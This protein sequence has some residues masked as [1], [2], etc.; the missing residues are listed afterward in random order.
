MAN[1]FNKF[2]GSI[3]LGNGISEINKGAIGEGIKSLERASRS[4]N[5]SEVIETEL[6]KISYKIYQVENKKNS[7]DAFALL[8]VMYERL[9]SFEER[10]PYSFNTQLFLTTITWEMSKRNPELFRDE[11][12]G[13]YI[14]LR[15]LM[16]Q[17][18]GPQEILSNVLVAV[19]EI[20]LGKNE[21]EIGIKMS[22]LAGITSAQSWWVKGEAERFQGNTESAIDSF[23]NSIDEASISTNLDYDDAEHRDFAFL[24]LSYQS[25]ALMYEN[26]DANMA[27]KYIQEAIKIAYNTG[28]A[29]LLNPRF[30]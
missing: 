7:A 8:P 10:S 15:N 29:L 26:I 30:R 22:D 3:N 19:G 27:T 11:A 28:N 6:F 24:V 23:K 16:P 5:R 13:R 17:Y 18:L 20:E 1:N 4:N 25:M 12:I 21:A 9:L 2:I 14:R